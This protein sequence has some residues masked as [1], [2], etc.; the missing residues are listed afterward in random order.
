[1]R[2]PCDAVKCRLRCQLRITEPERKMVFNDYYS[3]S[4]IHS[5]WEYLAKRLCRVERKYQRR[6]RN[7]SGNRKLNI[8][9]NF[10]VGNEKKRVCKTM[11]LNTLNVSDTVVYTA[12]NKCNEDGV[13]IERDNR[14][15]YHRNKNDFEIY[16]V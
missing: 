15:R 1:M 5:Q 14:G 13:L 16:G 4:N 7:P 10:H 9:Y 12:M 3:L 11:F 6:D 8:E 2:D